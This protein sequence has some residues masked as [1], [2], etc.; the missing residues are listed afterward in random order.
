MKYS[1]ISMGDRY[2]MHLQIIITVFNNFL[3]D[4][5]YLQLV[6]GENHTSVD[7]SLDRLEFILRR[8]IKRL[9]DTI[10]LQWK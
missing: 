10:Y 8:G 5:K 3:I 2:I 9:F 6:C 1:V 4:I 7:S